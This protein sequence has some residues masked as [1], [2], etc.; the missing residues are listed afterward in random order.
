MAFVNRF[1]GMC[2]SVCLVCYLSPPPPP[3]PPPPL[4]LVVAYSLPTRV[5]GDGAKMPW[6]RSYPED[7]QHFREVTMGHAIIMG[8]KTF[9]SIGRPLPGRRNLVV[10]TTLTQHAHTGIEVFPS[11]DA[12][13][14]AACDGGDPLPMVIGGGTIYAQALSSATVLYLTE[15]HVKYEGSVCFPQVDEEWEEKREERHV[16]GP[17]VFRTLLRKKKEKGWERNAVFF[18]M[19]GG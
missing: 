17:L 5:I 16:S 8:R 6:G 7:L 13:I 4:A 14:Q 2:T 9:E 3:P 18:R 10:S 19:F 1:M 12:A 15:I 11:L